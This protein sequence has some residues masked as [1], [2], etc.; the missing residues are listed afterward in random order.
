MARKHSSSRASRPSKRSINLNLAKKR[1]S[2]A[3]AKAAPRRKARAGS[4]TQ[5]Y[6]TL[7]AL[8][9]STSI[10]KINFI[11]T[12]ADCRSTQMLTIPAGKLEQVQ[13]SILEH[14]VEERFHSYMDQKHHHLA[15]RKFMGLVAGI[16]IVIIL[17]LMLLSSAL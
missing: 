6:A 16:L 3:A 5:T 4:A 10:D 7:C 8:C 17:A 1:P 13:N 9:G 12:C 11:D 2:R 15:Y 14:H